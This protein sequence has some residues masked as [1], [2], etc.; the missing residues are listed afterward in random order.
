M[1]AIKKSCKP[2]Q[3]EK[4]NSCISLDE[5]A[6]GNYVAMLLVMFKANQLIY[7]Y[8]KQI[9]ALTCDKARKIIPLFG[10]VVSRIVWYCPSA[11]RTAGEVISSG[12]I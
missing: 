1:K 2:K 8:G 10:H 4:T 7:T 5:V 6:D 3:R 12:G 11:E 9:C